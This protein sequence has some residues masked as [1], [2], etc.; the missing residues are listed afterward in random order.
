MF[1]AYLDA[2]MNMFRFSI[3]VAF[4]VRTIAANLPAQESPKGGEERARM[5][6]KFMERKAQE[7]KARQGKDGKEGE[8]KDGKPGG[9]SKKGEGKKNESKPEAV[10]PVKLHCI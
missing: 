2:H 10:K 8:R 3:F 9:E 1:P 6:Q 4:L 7:A 5:M